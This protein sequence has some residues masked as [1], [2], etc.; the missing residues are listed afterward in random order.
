MLYNQELIKSFK[1]RVKMGLFVKVVF[2]NILMLVMSV[3]AVDQ[4]IQVDLLMS[5]ITMALKEKRYA[6]ALPP[7]EKIE[8]MENS[9]SKPLTEGFHFLYLDTL[10]KSGNYAKALTRTNIYMEKFGKRGKHYA[11]V[12]D[13][14]VRLQETVEKEA[15]AR[16]ERA[17]IQRQRE[18]EERQRI[19]RQEEEEY[20]R[21]ERKRI[22]RQREQE[23]KEEEKQRQR[24]E[25]YERQ[26]QYQD[27]NR[28]VPVQIPQ[29]QM[30][31]LPGM[32]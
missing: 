3:Q 27:S 4:D 20:E 5:K 22:Q 6:D 15:I 19:E 25:R 16:E 14:T 18:E 21:A 31:M 28:F 23:E 10:D 32:Y 24:E 13:M 12:V 7:M 17:R 30:Y 26:N 29:R 11:Q 2:I 1:R 9:M 8:G